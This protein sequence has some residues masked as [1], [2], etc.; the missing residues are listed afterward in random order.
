MRNRL[1]NID[2]YVARLSL[3]TEF[4]SVFWPGTEFRRANIGEN[5]MFCML[6]VQ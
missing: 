5:N 1:S 6:V 4:L 2:W 3:A